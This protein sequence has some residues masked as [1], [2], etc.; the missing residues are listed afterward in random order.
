MVVS[1]FGE[2]GTDRRDYLMGLAGL[3]AGIHSLR[4]L[5]ERGIASPADIGVAIAGITPVL[6]QIPRSEIQPG[7]IEALTEL[8]AKVESAAELNYGTGT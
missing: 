6:N 3:S 8:L 2:S 4:I 1:L 5:A 7:T